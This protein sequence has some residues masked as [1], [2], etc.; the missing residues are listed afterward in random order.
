MHAPDCSR[1]T[2]NIKKKC[3]TQ[4]CSAVRCR[5]LTTKTTTV[6]TPG[7]ADGMVKLDGFVPNGGLPRL[8]VRKES[9][10][11]SSWEASS[12]CPSPQSTQQ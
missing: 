12:C 2:K 1:S 8:V 3:G 7:G 6:P 11:A 10:G 4:T 5:V 9:G